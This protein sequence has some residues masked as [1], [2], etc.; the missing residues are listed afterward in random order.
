M[1]DGPI[2]VMTAWLAGV[3]T[4][5]S[6][7]RLSSRGRGG[8]NRSDRLDSATEQRDQGSWLA[9][10]GRFVD[11]RGRTTG[12]IHPEVLGANMPPPETP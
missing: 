7:A 8:R 4:G 11:A 1:I 6:A 5:I 12:F 9:P 10:D 3:A 2:L